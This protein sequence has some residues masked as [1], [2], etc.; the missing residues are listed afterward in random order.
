MSN[1]R[2]TG[3]VRLGAVTSLATARTINDGVFQ[4]ISTPPALIISNGGGTDAMPRWRT[5]E[6]WA[7]A[8]ADN[9]TG[10]LSVSISGGHQKSGRRIIDRIGSL[11][12]TAGSTSVN[13]VSADV[14]S[15]PL[16][17]I[18]GEF[19]ADTM[20]WT[21]DANGV[22]AN[23]RAVTNSPIAQIYSPAN[24]R[25]AEITLPDLGNSDV[26]I[27]PWLDSGQT[28]TS[29]TVCYRWSV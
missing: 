18:T 14:A 15:T 3:I 7:A 1:L 5:L 10:T 24:N 17:F 8:N 2:S 11:A 27:E 26:I 13:D 6:L 22:Y 16:T 25:I 21:E 20:V 9:A 29:I 12:F 19:I 28:A 4:S 23:I